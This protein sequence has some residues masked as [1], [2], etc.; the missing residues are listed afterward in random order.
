MVKCAYLNQDSVVNSQLLMSIF[1]IIFK[2]K[3]HAELVQI[4]DK[5]AGKIYAAK[6]LRAE[7]FIG[8]NRSGKSKY[9]SESAYNIN[10]SFLCYHD[11]L[12]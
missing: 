3:F 2:C 5:I 4:V 10:N 6:L 8:E 7:I 1:A 9:S 12:T 11:T